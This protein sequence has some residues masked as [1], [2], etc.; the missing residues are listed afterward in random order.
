MA[1]NDVKV[2]KHNWILTDRTDL[3]NNPVGKK[4]VYY[5]FV[6]PDCEEVKIIKKYYG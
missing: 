3:Y 2:H 5:E 4:Y 6:C 1:N